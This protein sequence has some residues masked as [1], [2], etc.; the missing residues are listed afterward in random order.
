MKCQ[1]VT[2]FVVIIVLVVISALFSPALVKPKEAFAN[3]PNPNDPFENKRFLK[4]DDCYSE[5]GP[6]CMD[7]LKSIHGQVNISGMSKEDSENA[8]N[9]MMNNTYSNFDGERFGVNECVI[10][11]SELRNLHIQNCKLG[12]IQLKKNPKDGQAIWDYDNGCV[13]SEDQLKN[14]IDKIVSTINDVYLAPKNKLKDELKAANDENRE[15]TEKNW[16]EYRGNKKQTEEENKLQREALSQSYSAEERTKVEKSIELHNN[17]IIGMNNMEI[18][19][20][21]GMIAFMRNRVVG[22]RYEVYHGYFAMQQPEN[23]NHFKNFVPYETGFINQVNDFNGMRGYDNGRWTWRISVNITGILRPDVSGRWRFAL[24]SDDSSYM[25]IEPVTKEFNTMEIPNAF[26]KNP[27]W[28]GDNWVESQIEL[29]GTDMDSNAP[30][31]NLRIVQGNDG[32]PGSLRVYMMRP[33][34]SY[35]EIM[36][37]DHILFS[38]T[39]KGLQCK[40]VR[41]YFWD[42]TEWLKYVQPMCSISLDEAY[43]MTK[44]Y[45]NPN[46]GITGQAKYD[47]F[48]RIR[49]T[50]YNKNN[51]SGYN[52]STHPWTVAHYPFNWW[53]QRSM[54]IYGWFYPPVSGTYTFYLAS[55]DASYFWIGSNAVSWYTWN[56]WINNGGLHGTIM[57]KVDYH[58]GASFVNTPHPI[59]FVQGDYGGGNTLV[60]AYRKPGATQVIFDLTQ[61]FRH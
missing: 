51:N 13:V 14:N 30:G 24:V 21:Q 32:G 16:N 61:D 37:G 48:T 53:W 20:R 50:N 44:Q 10:S 57:R 49:Y 27:G 56:A 9:V 4:T 6:N 8:I 18:A 38:P 58:V 39:R 15:Q 2:L 54:N 36:S 12:E 40:V 52:E 5:T 1:L 60:F 19:K 46:F 26:L 34:R 17:K 33:N 55:D 11:E 41:G 47:N 23:L 3:C 7:V 22:L 31:Y 29:K 35:W 43:H 25:W 28:H 42:N 45:W 59:R